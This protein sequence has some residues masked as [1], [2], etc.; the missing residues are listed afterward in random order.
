M[1]LVVTNGG[2]QLGY[3]GGTPRSTLLVMEVTEGAASI[4]GLLPF[5]PFYML[6]FLPSLLFSYLFLCMSPSYFKFL[7]RSSWLGDVGEHSKVWNNG[8]GDRQRGSPVRDSSPSPC[9]LLLCFFLFSSM[10]E[11]FFDIRA[12]PS[13]LNFSIIYKSLSFSFPAPQI[14]TRLFLSSH[15][16]FI[17]FLC[18]GYHRDPF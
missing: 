9:L 15:F 6:L 17:F 5:L 4:R 12:L 13:L 1:R 18:L 10:H 2:S 16:F 14:L 3:V 8:L 7:R 11:L